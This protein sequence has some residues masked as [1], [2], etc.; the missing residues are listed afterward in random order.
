M[1]SFFRLDMEKI[2]QA[3]FRFASGQSWV[4]VVAVD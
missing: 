4:Q 3:I 2:G 1:S